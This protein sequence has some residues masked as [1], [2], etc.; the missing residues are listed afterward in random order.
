MKLKVWIPVL[1]LQMLAAFPAAAAPATTEVGPYTVCLESVGHVLDLTKPA[2]TQMSAFISL[3]I[4]GETEALEH[5][6]EMAQEPE[7]TDD[8][9]NSLVF[10][11]IRLPAR[12]TPNG[13]LPTT[14]PIEVWFS[15]MAPAAESLKSF[16][17]SLVCYEKKES[18]RLDF[19]CVAEEE[20]CGQSLEG[21][22]ITPTFVGQKEDAEEKPYQ[23]EV[24]IRSSKQEP[25]AATQWRNEQVELID[26]D[27]QPKAA[28][29]IS[30]TYQYDENGKIAART[31]TATFATPS[32]PPRGVRYRVER[33]LG[34]QTL[35]YQFEDL[36]L[37]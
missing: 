13:S 4:Q 14:I 30:R 34:V 5:L 21:L 28:L 20:F 27:G 9:E 23:V 17:A 37:P 12:F 31:I 26:A 1:I 24:E 18:L 19:I 3:S 10:Q 29:S 2:G 32:H 33:I 22:V 15:D 11:Q 35:P 7:A 8:R 25:D 6:L 36:P 16:S